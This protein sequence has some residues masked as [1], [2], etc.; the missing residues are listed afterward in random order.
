MNDLKAENNKIREE[1]NI[2]PDK[3]AILESS[4][5][6]VRL[7]LFYRFLQNTFE[8]EKCSANLVIYGVP[9]SS[10]SSIPQSVTEDKVASEKLLEPIDTTV[11]ITFKLVCLENVM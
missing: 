9:E 8:R 4:G 1:M 5:Y 7:R 2:L 6:P 3:I 11:P 10:T